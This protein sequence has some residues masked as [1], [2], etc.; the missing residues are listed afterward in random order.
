MATV[1]PFIAVALAWTLAPI[2]KALALCLL[3]CRGAA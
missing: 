2:L 3:L 1:N